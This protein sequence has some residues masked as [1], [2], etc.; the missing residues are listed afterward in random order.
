ML[1]LWDRW[2]QDLVEPAPYGDTTTYHLGADWLKDCETVE[3]W[4]C[5]KGWLRTLIEP[6]RYVGV[7]GSVTPFADVVA[8]LAEYR[9]ATPGL[10]MRHV[11]E[12]NDRW[13]DILDNAAASFTQRMALIIFTPLV[14][15]TRQIAWSDDPG[16]PDIAFNLSD[17]TNRF[18]CDWT[19]ETLATNTQY[20]AE[21][22]FRLAR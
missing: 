1:G 16:V 7:D 2:Y 21:T 4:G 8:D 11:L 9:S 10:F 5:G 13:A 6:G 3:D 19:H 22:V 14:R 12:H 17:L 18:G 20:G 15:H